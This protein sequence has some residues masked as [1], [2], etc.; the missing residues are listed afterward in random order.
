MLTLKHGEADNLGRSLDGWQPRKVSRSKRLQDW[1]RMPVHPAVGQICQR[2]F[3]GWRALLRLL[4][5]ASGFGTECCAGNE[6]D[7]SR[8]PEDYGYGLPV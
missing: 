7:R 5:M 4:V 1:S 2:S 3:C 6:Q 8:H